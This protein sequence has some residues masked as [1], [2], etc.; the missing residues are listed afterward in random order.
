MK[1]KTINR[2]KPIKKRRKTRKLIKRLKALLCRL[3]GH[4]EVWVRELRPR[5]TGM[6]HKRTANTT[7][8]MKG[9]AWRNYIPVEYR[10][11]SRCGKK[12]STAQRI[13]M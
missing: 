12:L 5:A 8:G 11:C 3:F 6:K 2:L 9:A 13:K 10:K 7:Q 4:R 1:R